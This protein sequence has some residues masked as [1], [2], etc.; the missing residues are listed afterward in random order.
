MEATTM[1]EGK[2]VRDLIPDRIRETGRKAEVR[3]LAGDALV[4]ALGAKLIE[5]A[6]EAAEAVGDRERLLEEL[7]DVRE[8]VAA[9]MDVRGITGEDITRAATAKVQQRGAFHSGAWLLSPVPAKIREY[10]AADVEAQRVKWIPGRWKNVFAGHEAA[11]KALIDHSKA[12]GGIARSFVHAQASGDPV[13]L[14]LMAMAWGYRPKDYGTART[15]QILQQ[16]RAEEKIAAIV[17]A[18]RHDGAAAGWSALLNTHRI[19]GLNM[20]FG[21]K[22]LY[23]AGYFA[24]HRPRPLVLDQRVRNSLQTLAPGTVPRK[25]KVWTADYLRYLNLAEE[26]AAEPTWAQEPDVVEYALFDQ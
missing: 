19:K 22:L 14:F 11:Y 13:D 4:A 3:Y 21:T 24:E 7:A 25:G 16:D 10:T 9:L 2:L 12:V 15:E 5:E 20:A 8:V 1:T 26:W 6:H 17:H 23:F 18:T